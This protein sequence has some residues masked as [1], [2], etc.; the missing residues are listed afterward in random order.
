MPASKLKEYP[1]HMLF[2][3]KIK[4]GSDLRLLF[5]RKAP[6]QMEIGSGKGTFL[7]SQAKAFPDINF[8]GIEWASK[9]YRH[10]V[11]RMGRWGLKNVKM[12][13][14]DAAV[15]I[16]EKIADECIDMYHIYF[17]DPWP[18]KRHHKRRFFSVSN[19]L[20][21]LRTL[22]P[23]GII[24]IATDHDG[25]FEQIQEVCTTLKAQ[26]KIEI[27][28]YIRPTGAK[29]GEYAGTN[30]ERK[31]IKEGRSINAAAIQKIG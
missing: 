20:Q 12:M 19:A 10:A 17:P 18:K 30:F 31:Y 13:R 6:I 28:E 1:Q 14:T 5:E 7:V 22:V 26:G 8:I 4:P 9:F 3:G 16:S 29:E 24:N 23:G 2:D 11:D 21:M 15:F 27:I 25:Y